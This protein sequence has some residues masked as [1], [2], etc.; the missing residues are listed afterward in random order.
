MTMARYSLQGKVAL[1]TGGARGIGLGMAQ[2]FIARGANV[3]LLDLEAEEVQRSAATLGSDRAIGIGADVT[4]ATALQAAVATTVE[5]F[6]GIDV[7]VANAGIAPTPNTALNMDPAE[8]ERVVEVDLLGVYRTV[9]AALPHVIERR[10]QV[11]LVSSV[12]A[13]MNGML[14]SPYAVSKAGVEQLGR[15]LRVE[16]ASHGASATVAY[17]GFVDTKMVQDVM[18]R[19]GRPTNL[20]DMT[21]EFIRR[22]I[23]PAQAGE[24]V[25]EAVL[26]RRARVIAP[27]FWTTMSVLRGVVNPAFDLVS[28]RQQRVQD[29]IREAEIAAGAAE[30]ESA[31]SPNTA[32]TDS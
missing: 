28:A 32:A 23:T 6:G 24:A 15:A 3:A 13:F 30:E 14:V 1:I 17:F 18:D 29:A 7:V 11:V 10:G 21:P 27:R 20:E 25:A 5:R 12:Y 22:R 2:A 19:E 4:D 9:H 31:G 16:L 26:R 8:F